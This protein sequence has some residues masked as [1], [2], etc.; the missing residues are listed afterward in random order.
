V[1]APF[2]FDGAGTYY[3]KMANIPNYINSWNLDSLVINGVELKNVWVSSANLPAKQ[4][5]YYYITYKGSYPWSHFE[6]K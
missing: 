2:S 6:A 5:G 3:W 1:T 4:N